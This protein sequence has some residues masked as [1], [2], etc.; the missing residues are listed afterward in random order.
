MISHDEA[1]ALVE[2]Y[3]RPR[4]ELVKRYLGLISDEVREAAKAG[5][6]SCLVTDSHKWHPASLESAIKMMDHRFRVTWRDAV[7]AGV[8]GLVVSWGGE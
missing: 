6:L 8:R 5:C 1:M 7:C 3:Q 4:D 2:E